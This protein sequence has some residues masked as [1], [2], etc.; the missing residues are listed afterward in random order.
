M[1][2]RPAREIRRQ[3]I[4]ARPIL[5]DGGINLLDPAQV[6]ANQH[7]AGRNWFRGEDM[8]IRPRPGNLPW[9]P[10]TGPSAIPPPTAPV[11][12]PSGI[13]WGNIVAQWTEDS[14]ATWAAVTGLAPEG[15][16]DVWAVSTTLWYASHPNGIANPR[17]IRKSA[18]GRTFAVHGTDVHSVRKPRASYRLPSG[19]IVCGLSSEAAPNDKLAV[20]Y[21][22]D[23]AATWTLV[24]V[25]AAEVRHTRSTQILPISGSI[26]A[27]L[28]DSGNNAY[29]R[30]TDG[31]ATWTKLLTATAFAGSFFDFLWKDPATGYV[32][33]V[34]TNHIGPNY[35]LLRSTD[36]GASFSQVDSGAV[37]TG[38]LNA[39]MRSQIARWE[40]KL[41]WSN[42][43]GSFTGRQSND[44][45][46]V[47]TAY[48]GPSTGIGGCYRLKGALIA[49][50]DEVGAGSRSIDGGVT[51]VSV[52]AIAGKHISFASPI[53]G[54]L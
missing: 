11:F 3:Q 12:S 7:V 32:F 1:P 34:E 53:T 33:L 24:V 48:T 45:G 46:A 43:G 36:Q 8:V 40:G 4:A 29:Y 30:S 14:G 42:R 44:N 9:D 2:H 50:G 26:L 6:H 17:K 23:D 27:M 31:A 52:P 38:D 28:S 18:D 35:R 22:D 10:V 54:G 37:K 47:W 21:S 39:P 41:L 16:P 51:W 20:V 19:R 15:D 13:V 49:A 5:F 25:D